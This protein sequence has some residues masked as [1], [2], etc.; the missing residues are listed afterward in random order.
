MSDSFVHLHVHTEFSMLDGAARIGELFDET[1]AARDAGAGDHR[2]R[3]RVRR[4]RV[5]QGGQGAR[6]Q[7][8]HRHRGLPHA[9]H[10]PVRAAAGPVGQRRLR[11]RL[12]WR[13]LHPHHAARREHRGHA[14]PVP[15]VSL[16]SIEGQYYKP[17]MDRELL[18]RYAAGIIATTGCPSG[19]VQTL[20]RLGKYADALKAAADY[21]D[22]FG[23]DNYFVELMDHGLDDRAAGPRPTCSRSP[24]SSSLPLVATNDLHYTKREDAVGHEAL[25]CVQSGSTMNDANRFKF[26]GDGYYLKSPAEMREVWRDFPEAC[27]NTLLIAERCEV[28]FAEGRNLMPRFPVP[29]GETEETWFVKEVERGLRAPLP[30][31]HHGRGPRP[32]RPRDRVHPADGLPGLLP[33]DRR[34]HQLGQGARHPGR[35]GPWLG[36]RRDRRVR[37]GHHRAR[38][39]GARPAVRAVPQPRA[40]LDARHRHRLRRAPPRRGDPLRHR[41]VRRRPGR[42]DRHLR[43]HQGQAGDQGLLAGARLP[44]RDGRAHHQ[45]D[46]AAGDGQGHPA[47]RHLRPQPRPATARRGSSARCTRPTT[48][49]AGSSTPP[50]SSR[51]S[52]ASGACTPPA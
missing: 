36:D 49:S 32:R 19:E 25:L 37:H 39:A 26:D 23:A 1:V 30:G 29:E 4:V 42:P 28:E 10:Q 12:R 16:A 43:H 46:A 14:Q 7:A 6:R 44:V 50:A 22:I 35:P 34:L 11:R 2:P 8:D 52:S 38:P 17:R 31:R 9:R 18:E 13:R 33:R 21:R 27:D 47:Q 15:A 41:Q 20:I 48:T 24:R 51:T 40:R 3:Q 5:L 45:G